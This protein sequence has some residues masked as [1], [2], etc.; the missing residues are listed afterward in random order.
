MQSSVI[1]QLAIDEA[2]KYQGLTYPNPAVGAA[3]V[4]PKGE[5]LAIGVHQKAGGPHAEVVALKE[6]YR[7]LSDDVMI[8]TIETSAE[9]HNYLA[10][11]HNN[12]FAECTIYVTLEPC[13]HQGKTPSCAMLIK[14]LGLK[15]VVMAHEDPNAVAT[16]GKEIL[17]SAGIEVE[18]GLLREKAADLLLPFKQWQDKGF[19]VFKWAQRLE[20]TIDGGVISGGTSRRLVHAMRDRCDLLVIGGNTV[21][22]DRP[23]LDA[24]LVDGKAPDVLIISRETSF[25][26]SIPL[27]AVANR[28]V[29]ISDTLEATEGYNNI[30]I[31]GGPG[32][33]EL[34]KEVTDMYLCFVAPKSGGTIPFTKEKIDFKILHTYQLDKDIVL[35]LKG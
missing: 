20:G 11:H 2:W 5:L 18:T 6:A 35:W 27:F 23:T 34:T 1:M 26:Q 7:L 17:K 29:I 16:G 24:R 28:N 22:T 21:R 3:V 9:L 13:A 12:C 25:D 31:E 4:G 32:M 8:D 10:S 19:V 33:F 14:S 30:L 15:R